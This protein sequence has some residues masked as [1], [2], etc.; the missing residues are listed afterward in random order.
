M[1][2]DEQVQCWLRE[3]EANYPYVER[4]DGRLASGLALESWLEYE[5]GQASITTHLNGEF[6][7]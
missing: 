7:Q 2:E 3:M 4:V 1:S 6:G 5:E